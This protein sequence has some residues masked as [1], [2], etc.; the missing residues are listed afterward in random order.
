MRTPSMK[1][2]GVLSVMWFQSTFLMG[3]TLLKQVSLKKFGIAPANY[4][5]IVQVAPD[6]FA[7]IDDKSAMDGF[8]PF[9]I[10]QNSVTGEIEQ[11]SADTLHCD[12]RALATDKER[13]RTDCEDITYVPEWDTYFIASEA[14]Q[15]IYEYDAAGKRTG[16]CL[17]IPEQFSPQRIRHNGGFESVTYNSRTRLFWTTTEQPLSGEEGTVRP[18]LRVQSFTDDLQPSSQLAYRMEAPLLKPG[19]YYTHGIPALL[20]L[21]DGRLLVMERELSVP[22]KYIGSKT[23]IRVF[24]VDP[25][26]TEAIAPT[27]V[28][29]TLGEAQILKKRELFSFT[30]HIQPGK[31]NYGNYE[32]MAFGAKLADG[33]QTLLLI[34]DSQ[35][36][37]GNG[38]YRLKDYIKVVILPETF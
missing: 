12:R 33:R 27:T 23:Q 32:G 28:M 19:K 7:V 38:L 1:I 26:K 22:Q 35:A 5:G 31:I 24:V 9:R 4:S 21:E 8:I 37:A 13:S 6:S 15:E 20:A 10:I 3:Q 25:S 14:E 17:N 2:A 29:K 34:S 11:V 36:G 18:M 30:T 16:R